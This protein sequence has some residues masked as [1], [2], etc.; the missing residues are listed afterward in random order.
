MSIPK[1]WYWRDEKRHLVAELNDGDIELVVY[2]Y[3]I[4]SRQIWSYKTETKKIIEYEIELMAR[5][6]Q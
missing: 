6:N 4:S 3:W 2:K 1:I 5:D